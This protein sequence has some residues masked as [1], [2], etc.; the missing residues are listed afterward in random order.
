MLSQ[1]N[2]FENRHWKIKNSVRTSPLERKIFNFA[3]WF[4]TNSNFISHV[5]YY[6]LTF[7]IIGDSK[8]IN[9]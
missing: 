2:N 3:I 1:I 7:G 5:S 8:V 4:K 6:N 9:R